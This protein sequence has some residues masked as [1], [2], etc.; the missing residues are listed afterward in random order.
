MFNIAFETKTILFCYKQVMQ[1]AGIEDE[2]VVL[3]LEDHQFE[4]TDFLELINSLLSAGEIP[5]LYTPEELE[6]VLA[7][8]RDQAS[9]AGFRGTL[10]QYFASSKCVIHYHK[11]NRHN[12]GF[13]TSMY[14]LFLSFLFVRNTE[15]PSC[16]L[17]HGLFKQQV[18]RQLRE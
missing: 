10:A 9:D 13:R 17:D 7:P 11:S 3:V 15:K 8:L 12:I 2:Q 1:Q 6:P 5:G 4:G 14:S 18:L 16:C